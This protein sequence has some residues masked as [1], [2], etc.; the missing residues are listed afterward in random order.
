MSEGFL[1]SLKRERDIF[2]Q[3]TLSGEKTAFRFTPA[4][5]TIVLQEQKIYFSL[6]LP[7]Y[8][9]RDL[10]GLKHWRFGRIKSR[11]RLGVHGK[12]KRKIN[13]IFLQHFWFFRGHKKLYRRPDWSPSGFITRDTC[14]DRVIIP[15]RFLF[16][17]RFFFFF[18]FFSQSQIDTLISLVPNIR[19]GVF[20]SFIPS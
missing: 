19:L 18:F 4:L 1:D 13:C 8:P 5:K 7:I 9:K 3:P 20:F 16:L 2:V 10:D 15:V 12:K 14:G 11:S 17:F 6:F